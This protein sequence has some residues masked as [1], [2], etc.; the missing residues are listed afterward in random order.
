MRHTPIA[1]LPRHH[2]IDMFSSSEQYLSFGLRVDPQ[3]PGWY[4]SL[5]KILKTIKG[6]TYTIDAEQG[7][8]FVSGRANSKSILKKLR[9]SGLEVAW[10]RTGK[11]NIYSSHGHGYYQTNP[12]LQYPYQ[13]CHPYVDPQSP[14][15]YENLTKILK[16]IKGATYTIDAEQGMALISGRANSKSILKK[17]KKLGSEVAWIKTGKQDTYGSHGHGYYQANPCLQYPYQYPQHPNYHY[18][19]N[20]GDPYVPNPPHFEPYGYYSTRYC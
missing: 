8:A 19:T 14:G 9:K 2:F 12:Y 15:W 17:L 4:E 6:A 10:I 5:T 3:Y 7:L 13:Y 18:N 20:Y 11:L 16:L 1:P